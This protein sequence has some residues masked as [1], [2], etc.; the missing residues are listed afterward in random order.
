MKSDSLENRS[1]VFVYFPFGPLY[2][3]LLCSGQMQFKEEFHHFTRARRIRSRT[4][5]AAFEQ[6]TVWTDAAARKRV[7]KG[8]TGR[9]LSLCLEPAGL[10]CSPGSSVC[11][12]FWKVH[13]QQPP[14]TQSRFFYSSLF[15][16]VSFHSVFSFLFSLFLFSWPSVVS[17]T[18]TFQRTCSAWI[19][20]LAPTTGL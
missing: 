2:L 18:A 3:R 9:R 15:F 5:Q 8:R 20:T 1:S 10:A 6:F 14:N 16:L 13:R 4:T 11:Q 17:P 12:R 7:S 19:A